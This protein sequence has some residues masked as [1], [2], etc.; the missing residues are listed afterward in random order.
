M[1]THESL[2]TGAESKRCIDAFTR[3]KAPTKMV[4]ILSVGPFSKV[5]MQEAVLM[6]FP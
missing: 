4:I 1:N 6:C 5:D 3:K 2:Q